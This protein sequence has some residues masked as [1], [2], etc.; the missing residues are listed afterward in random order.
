MFILLAFLA[1]SNEDTRLPQDTQCCCK[2]PKVF[3]SYCYPKSKLSHISTANAAKLPH[4]LL[5]G[6]PKNATNRTTTN[7]FA[8]LTHGHT[9]NSLANLKATLWQPYMWMQDNRASIVRLPYV[10]RKS[11]WGMQFCLWSAWAWR[12]R[13]I[14]RPNDCMID[15]KQ[16]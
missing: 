4:T 10:W 6:C 5:H 13:K 11:T 2:T 9:S 15:V 8:W 12:L 14:A 16:I 7:K 1:Q 3:K